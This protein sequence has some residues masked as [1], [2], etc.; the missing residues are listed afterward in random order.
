MEERRLTLSETCLSTSR[1][2]EDS[3][4]RTTLNDSVGVREDGS[5]VKTTCTKLPSQL[6][7][8]RRQTPHVAVCSVGEVRRQGGRK[9][10]RDI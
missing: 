4:A 7:N 3:R 2:T 9:T 6:S 10:Y 5:N 1:L 8:F